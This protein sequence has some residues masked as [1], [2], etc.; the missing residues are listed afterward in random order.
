MTDTC[1]PAANTGDAEI[2]AAF[3]NWT[4]KENG[5][6]AEREVLDRGKETEHEGPNYGAVLIQWAWR[7]FQA[8]WNRRTPDDA[9]VLA[10]ARVE[11][12][13][14]RMERNHHATKLPSLYERIA[15]LEAQVSDM[16]LA[17]GA[18]ETE[19]DRL[20]EDCAQFYQ[21]IGCLADAAGLW[22]SDQVNKALDNANAA[23]GSEPR[24]HSDLLPF[25]A[26]YWQGTR[27]AV[28][29]I[30]LK[31]FAEFADADW[32]VT[33]WHPITEDAE[34]MVDRFGRRIVY[35]DLLNARAALVSS[36]SK[37]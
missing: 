9:T 17:N 34:L 23:A 21:V 6:L 15:E 35:R 33:A 5:W 25:K 4:R 1:T 20:R 19:V 27:I 31:P 7:G 22:D 24:P 12:D 11:I 32:S 18:L 3:D 8:A 28:L 2:R 26:S 36:D 30:A 37:E 16:R 29:E 13:R 14:L 10:A